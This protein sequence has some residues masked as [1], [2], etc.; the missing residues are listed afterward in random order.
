MNH[1]DTIIFN[2]GELVTCAAGGK[3]KRRAE[4]ADVGIIANGAVAIAD[5][6]FAAVGT[7]EEILQE[8]AAENVI[9]VEG[10]VICPGFVD[11]H[12]H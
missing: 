12:T 6:K 10:K 5:G 8:F 2:V 11:P 9:D 3:P 7:T 4:M 1:V